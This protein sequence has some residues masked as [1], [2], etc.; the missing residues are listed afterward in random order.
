MNSYNLNSNNFS[1]ASINVI[2]NTLQSSNIPEELTLSLSSNN[3]GPAEA[4]IIANALQSGNMPLGLT[5]DLGKNNFGPNGTTAIA[6]ALQS[7]HVPKGLTLKLE[8][9]HVGLEGAT[10]IANALQSGNAPTG[11][12]LNLGV[13]NLGQDGAAIAI[14]NALQSGKAPAELTLNLWGNRIDSTGTIAIANALQSGNAPTGLTLILSRNHL[15]ELKGA[16]AIANAL[17]F[18]SIPTGLMLD[19]RD[20]KLCSGGITAIKSA[21]AALFPIAKRYQLHI[22]I[23]EAN[24]EAQR[25]INKLCYV[26]PLMWA[27]LV[28]RC[29]WATAPNGHPL[30]KLPLE[31]VHQILS[32]VMEDHPAYQKNAL[33]KVETIWTQISEL[34]YCNPRNYPSHPIKVSKLSPWSSYGRMFYLKGYLATVKALTPNQYLSASIRTREL[35]CKQIINAIANTLAEYN[36]IWKHPDKKETIRTS[37]C[38]LSHCLETIKKESKSLEAIINDILLFFQKGSGH[39][40]AGKKNS[41]TGVYSLSNRPSIKTLLMKK[42]L[43]ISLFDRKIN[44]DDTLTLI[45]QTESEENAF[46]YTLDLTQDKFGGCYIPGLICFFENECKRVAG[47]KKPAIREK[48]QKHFLS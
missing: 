16:I 47:L 17:Q 11:L 14:A 22:K 30:R 43:T 3:L 33:S 46:Q 35:A 20:N 12:T 13:N 44:S 36:A 24:H 9:N 39:W 18:G 2:T 42:L 23:E 34:R 21:I 5:L 15:L 19:L 7:G 48:E 26:E 25:Q 28:F 29:I 40:H 37:F 4:I 6:N 32:Y 45:T 38:Q 27:S 1:S 31:L 10:A 8:Y 41:K